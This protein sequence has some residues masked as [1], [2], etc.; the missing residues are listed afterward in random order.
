MEPSTPS[1]TSYQDDKKLKTASDGALQTIY[2]A[3]SAAADG[4]SVSSVV[5][6]ISSAV[7]E[8]KE[9]LDNL[10][11]EV[12]NTSATVTVMQADLVCMKSKTSQ[13]EKE[14]ITLN[15][16][17]TTL[18]S[19]TDLIQAD[20]RKQRDIIGSN[21]EKIKNL[22]D[23]LA[24][25]EDSTHRSNLRIISLPGGAEGGDA[26]TFLQRHLPVWP[27][28]L[29]SRGKIEIKRAHRIYSAAKSDG[30]NLN[31][32]LIFKLLG[33]SDRKAIMDT[34]RAAGSSPSHKG[35]RL[36][37]FAD[38]CPSTSKLR[39]AFTQVMSSLRK[40]G[41]Q[42]FLIYPAKLRVSVLVENSGRCCVF[43]DGW[44][45]TQIMSLLD[46]SVWLCDSNF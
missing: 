36:L 38:Y 18:S 31:R 46:P 6:R 3:D 40:K 1:P 14:F 29:S 37:L 34:Y 43:A 9:S 33:Y 35:H 20:V 5:L 26:I 27:P 10:R 8:I 25:M 11:K 42:H 2:T 17:I 7:T 45:V 12:S 4:T 23:R 30:K 15:K 28:S 21:I 13:I 24:E 32:T 16:S 22:T 19:C 39:K 44:C 41:I